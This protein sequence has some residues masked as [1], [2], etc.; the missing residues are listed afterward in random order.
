ML[1]N[2]PKRLNPRPPSNL[3]QRYAGTA[4]KETRRTVRPRSGRSDDGNK[5][6]PIR[7]IL[8]A[9]GG[10]SI[11][12]LLPEPGLSVSA[13]P[14]CAQDESDSTRSGRLGGSTLES[15]TILMKVQAVD[16]VSIRS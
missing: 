2:Q 13:G 10:H 6:P 14:P 8:T 9:R 11:T 12:V 7:V 5:T 1:L 16:P 3:A 4:I 15:G